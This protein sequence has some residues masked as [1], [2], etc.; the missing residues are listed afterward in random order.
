MKDT[1]DSNF[2]MRIRFHDLRHEATSHLFEPGFNVME[3]A[4]ITG[5]RTLQMRKCYT[6][7]RCRRPGAETWLTAALQNC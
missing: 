6:H 1:P 7:L 3:V 5:H 2:L 4:T